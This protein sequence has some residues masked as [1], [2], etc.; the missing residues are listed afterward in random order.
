M[1]FRDLLVLLDGSPR[2]DSKLTVASALARRTGAH[3]T[4]LCVLEHLLPADASM[5]VG[6]YP[7]AWTLPQLSREMEATARARADAIEAMFRDWL[8]REL[9]PG[10]WILDDGPS[11]SAVARRA[12]VRDLVILG[13]A[14]PASPPPVRTLIEGVL[15]ASGRPLLLIP[16]AGRFEDIGSNVLIGWSDTREAARAVHDA[17][18]LLKEGAR[19]TVLT[20]ESEPSAAHTP[21][22]ADMAE[23]LARHGLAAS[24]EKTVLADGLT[25]ADALLA[26]AADTGAD[27][28][29]IG[30]YGHSRTREMVLGGVTRDLLRHMTLPV[31]MS[32]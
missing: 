26:A 15:M 31:L 29:V 30:G 4:G 16:Y 7:E 5:L 3:V 22:N 13:Q 14:D 20:A 12:R 9:A 24:F 25:P 2:D 27:M 32:H 10:E 21:A 8:R 11:I 28:L 17:L 23:H 19:V 18:P 6:G 1:S